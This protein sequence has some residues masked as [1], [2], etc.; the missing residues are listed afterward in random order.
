MKKRKKNRK[1]EKIESVA[2]RS[3]AVSREVGKKSPRCLNI[4]GVALWQAV[5]RR[6]STP[7]VL[8]KCPPSHLGLLLACSVVA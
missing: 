6:K 1:A 2:D 4:Y 3:P 7:S 8:A 5:R